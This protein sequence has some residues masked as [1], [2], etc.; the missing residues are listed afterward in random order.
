MRR[1]AAILHK[2][3]RQHAVAFLLLLVCEAGAFCLLLLGSWVGQETVSLMEAL[4]FFLWIFLPLGAIVL[5]NRLVVAEYRGRTQLFLE[6]LPVYRWEMVALKLG[7]GLAVLLGISF[8]ALL[9]NL[10]VASLRETIDIGFVGVLAVRTAAFV[11]FLWTF[12]FA[13]GFVGRFRVPIYLGLLLALSMLDQM[14]AFEFQRFGPFAVL[15]SGTFAF[16]REL[17]QRAVVETVLLGVF[18]LGIALT[19]ALIHEGSL[20]EEL[21]RRMSQKE[22]ALVGLLFVALLVVSTVLDE[23][24]EKEPFTF[25]QE[26]VVWSSSELSLHLLYL[27]DEMRSDAEGLGERLEVDLLGLRDALDWT[28]LPAVRVAYRSS[29]GSTT[30]DE[31][32]L[33]AND[34]ILVRANFQEAPQWDAAAFSAYIV[35]LVLDDATAGRAGFE[36]KAWVRDGFSRWWSERYRLRRVD[37][38]GPEGCDDVLLLRALWLSRE[39][40]VDADLLAS[41][42]RLEERHGEAM[43][44]GLA[45]A[46]MSWIEQ[47][48]G[49]DAVLKLARNLFGRESPKDLRELFYERRHPMAVV[50]EE[51]TGQS[52]QEFLVSWGAE[53]ERLRGEPECRAVLDAVPEGLAEIEVEVGEGSIRHLSYGFRFTRPPPAGALCS[54]LHTGLDPFDRVVDPDDLVRREHSWSEAENAASW[55]LSGRYSRGSRVFLA[56]E[57]EAPRLGC[58]VRLLASRQVIQ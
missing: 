15:D 5:S 4:G 43:T 11:F 42:W 21:S 46:A 41:W 27:K 52:W 3:L 7:L 57:V 30:Y 54:L 1:V 17:P 26:E 20:A 31:A 39:Q 9:V 10:G 51:A 40:Q 28:S 53:L 45:Y 47:L 24:R 33:Q 22:K 25:T 16:A 48:H 19:L 32:T 38:S 36:P 58:A 44:D 50:F 29:L 18:S 35:G 13:M 56:L 34:G 8:L 2:E 37:S 12:F 6:A 14:T 49:E 55:R 23:R